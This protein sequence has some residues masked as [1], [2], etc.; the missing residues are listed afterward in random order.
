MRIA[1]IRRLLACALAALMLTSCATATTPPPGRYASDGYGES[2]QYGLMA[3]IL[4]VI[5]LPL[6]IPLKIAVC[7]ATVVLAAPATAI[8]AVTD[9]YG[10]GWQRQDLADGFASNCGLP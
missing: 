1:D 7:A 9:P 3:G 6:Y 2:P 10:T 4:N 8:T 5:A